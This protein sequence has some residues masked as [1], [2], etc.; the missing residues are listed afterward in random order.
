ME[1]PILPLSGITFLVHNERVKA[2]CGQSRKWRL[3]K[4]AGAWA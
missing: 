4:A 2:F 3:D 1:Q